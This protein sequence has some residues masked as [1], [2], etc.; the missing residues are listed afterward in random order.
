MTRFQ[1]KIFF[2]EKFFKE[3]GGMKITKKG[4]WISKGMREF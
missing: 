3:K 1:I 4:D 2:K